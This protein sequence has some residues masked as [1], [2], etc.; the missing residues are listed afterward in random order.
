[1]VNF[2]SRRFLN[3]EY[4]SSQIIKRHGIFVQASIVRS[5][6]SQNDSYLKAHDER[7]ASNPSAAETKMTIQNLPDFLTNEIPRAAKTSIPMTSSYKGLH[8]LQI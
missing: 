2:I 8:R 3:P 4:L 6:F 7:C 1:M 5:T